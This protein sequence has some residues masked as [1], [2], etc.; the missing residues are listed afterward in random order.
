MTTRYFKIKS[1]NIKNLGIALVLGSF[2]MFF[3]GQSWSAVEFVKPSD[4]AQQIGQTEIFPQGKG[5][6]APKSHAPEPTTM[7]LVGSGL[8]SMLIGFFRR[9]Y[10]LTKRGIDII[11]SVI[12]LIFCTPILLIIAVLVKLTSQGPVF[13]TQ[14]RVGKDGKHFDI[15]KFRTMNVD[16]EKTTGPVWAA[17]NDNRLSPVGG[18]LR[19]FHLDEI[20]Q[21]IN[22][23]IGDM[24]IIGPRPERPVFVEQFKKEIPDYEKRLYVKPGITGLAQIWHHY[25]ETIEDVHKKIK[26]DMLYIKNMC[27]WTDLGIL[28]RTVRVVLTGAEAKY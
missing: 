18:F 27:F 17:K 12:G 2:Y 13:Y 5:T 4:S 14:T 11:G 21:F 3:A 26:Y 24:S 7:A 15:Y 22:V 19:K 20:P 16:A 8:L 10:G 9:A 25:D 1:K 23:L 6:A 28:F